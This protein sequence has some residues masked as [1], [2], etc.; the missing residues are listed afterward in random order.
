MTTLVAIGYPD[1]TTAAAAAQEAERRTYD[2]VFRPDA[3]AT[4]S[5]DATGRFRTTTN[6]HPVARGTW[7]G[8][9]WGALFGLLLFVPWRGLAAGA[10]FGALIGAVSKAAIDSRYQRQAREMLHP[11]TSA[12]FLAVDKAS[13]DEAISALKPFGG[14]V[15]RSSLPVRAEAHLREVLHGSRQP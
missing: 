13:T 3:I 5:R 9:F 7:W 10:G 14:R 11:G 1:R 12:L 4:V 2:L 6:R 8:M 15:L